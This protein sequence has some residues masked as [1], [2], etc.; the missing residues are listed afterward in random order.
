MKSGRMTELELIVDLHLGTERQGPGSKA[1]TLTALQL[2]PNSN[3]I[4]TVA[5][6]GCGTGGQTLTLAQHLNA[7]IT[8]V[9]LFPEFLEEVNVRAQNEGV[10][11]QIGVLQKSID[12]LP[13][14]EELD[15]IW[16]EGAIYNL[17]FKNGIQLWKDYLKP[18]GYLAVS[19]ITWIT[20]SRPKEI[21]EFWTH[22]YP[23]ISQAKDKIVDLEDNGYNLVGYFKLPPESWLKTYYEPLEKTIPAFLERHDHSELAQ[24]VAQEYLDELS[25]YKKYSKYFSYGFYIA[26][27]E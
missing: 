21:Q 13:F 18:G 6:L 1:I 10:A 17:G 19:E 2:I 16:S 15:L 24:K 12:D 3:D 8:A 25:L 14:K 27:K 11:N 4:K 26:Q 22:A 9:D 7:Q 20:G 23:E 5:D